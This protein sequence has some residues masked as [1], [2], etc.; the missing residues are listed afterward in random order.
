MSVS[1]SKF[2]SVA[3][4]FAPYQ[5]QES[6]AANGLPEVLH[7]ETGSGKTAGIILPWLWM[8]TAH[9]DVDV[10]NRTPRWLVYCTP[11]RTITEQIERAVIEWLGNLDKAGILDLNDVA[12]H[13]AIGGSDHRKDQARWRDNPAGTAIVIGTLDML[14]SRALNR[15]YAMNRFAWPIDFGL[16]NNGCH[17]VFDEVQLMGPALPTSRQLHGLR[18]KLGTVLAS[19]GTWMSATL[20][21][22]ILETVDCPGPEK[23]NIVELSDM[24]DASSKELERRLDAAKEL[25]EV[26]L[27]TGDRASRMAEAL[28]KEH[29][30]GTLTLAVFNTV[31]LAKDVYKKV[32]KADSSLPVILLHSRFRPQ[33]RRRHLDDALNDIDQSGPGRIVVATQVIEAGVD[34][35]AATL[36]TEAAPWSSMVQ[37]AGRCNRDGL[38][39]DA[40][41]LWVKVKEKNASPYNEE[42]VRDAEKLLR[43][44][45]GEI[46]SPRSLRNH[47]VQVR[48]PAVAILRRVDLTGLFDT[49]PDI[50]GNDVDI[51]SFI[52]DGD[53]LNAFLAWRD[54]DNP[55]D[56]I[57]LHHLHLGGEELCPVPVSKELTDFLRREKTRSW[58]FDYVESCW[59]RV[60]LS[61]VRPGAIILVSSGSG[62]YG[63]EIG[64]DPSS[65]SAVPSVN[66]LMVGNS[67][68][69]ITGELVS[70]TSM[71]GATSG[72]I[73][74]AVDEVEEGI[75][76]DPL[77]AIG[78]WVPLVDHLED[79]EQAV[80]DLGREFVA[81][82]PELVDT[83][84]VAGR[85]HD[86]GKAHRTFQNA[87]TKLAERRNV[88]L[89]SGPWAK[90]GYN[91]RLSY[92]PP[93]FRH[94]LASA[95]ALLGEGSE[96]LRNVADPDLVIYLVAAHH[97]RVRLGIRSAPTEKSGNV[98]GIVEGDELGPV[99]IPGGEMLTSKLSLQPAR[100]GKAPDGTPSWSE[101]MTALLDRSDM[102]PFRLGFLEA[103]VRLADWRASSV[104]AS[105]R[106]HDGEEVR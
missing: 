66:G 9:P 87:L 97:G 19:S 91:D 6:I 4:G 25:R 76:D 89:G 42:D 37:R 3:T 11:L 29:R 98:L 78:C 67:N 60:T 82:P 85:L 72:S 40:R 12:V 104:D 74:I 81:V 93:N 84:A 56:E 14:L 59:T 52:R 38:V 63:T 83:A 58:K 68:H 55:N 36:F 15:G 57:S 61:D 32:R 31:A 1:F 34:V 88:P 23:K 53:D 22:N 94:E 7:A 49:S 8:R 5:Y 96:L 100:L 106:C 28:I 95:L 54:L 33:E 101:R 71:A 20:D 18:Q 27:P 102:G 64:W 70:D 92:D 48:Q 105:R 10:R 16:F 41:F 90:S 46:V 51:S 79:V 69:E 44:H 17:W 26:Q 47:P 103:L 73:T 80:G 13:I 21:Y 2:F 99:C 30:K 65:T 43:R 75:A 35:S 86:V 62:G 77:T 50:S 24:D 39:D 45:E